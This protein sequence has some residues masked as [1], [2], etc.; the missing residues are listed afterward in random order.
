ML[1]NGHKAS[2]ESFDNF[3]ILLKESNAFKLQLKGFLSISCD[4]QKYL[5]ISLGTV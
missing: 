4:E 5:L 1:L 3:S 2:F